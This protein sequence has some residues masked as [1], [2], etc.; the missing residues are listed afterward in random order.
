MPEPSKHSNVIQ[1]LK[2]KG[3]DQPCPRCGGRAFEVLDTTNIGIEHGKRGFYRTEQ[4]LPV[5]ITACGNCGF[6][7]M[8]SLGALGLL[9]LPSQT[10]LSALMASIASF[11]KR[12]ISG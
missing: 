2:D 12:S 1:A 9:L 6:I 5:A 4:I 10:K 7:A 3:A 11:N 8:H